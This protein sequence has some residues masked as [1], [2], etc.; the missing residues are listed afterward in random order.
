M[1]GELGRRVAAVVVD[2]NSGDALERCVASLRAAGV[3]TVVVVD[4]AA[5]ERRVAPGTRD[6]LDPPGELGSARLVRPSANLGYGAGVNLG[7]GE[8]GSDVELLLVCNPDVVVLPEAVDLLVHVLDE[9]AELAVAGPMLRDSNGSIYPSG[10]SFPTLGESIGHGFFGMFWRTNPWTA[11]YRLL[12]ADQQRERDADWVSGACML[13]RRVAFDAV[14]GFDQRYFM[15]VEDVDLCWRLRREGW[16]TR[17]VPGAQVVHEQGRST[18]ARPYRML[19]AHHRS[20]MRFAERST[21][22]YRRS[23]LPLVAVGLIA[24]LG[25]ACLEHLVRARHRS[26]RGLVE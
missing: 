8:L 17:Y 21:T 19:V 24:R 13:V 25:L 6:E 14:G 26:P 5:P 15:Y 9:R 16:S 11:R 20:M 10:R 3:S 7:A 2:F 18:A 4:N 23:M 12:G 22:G 1:D